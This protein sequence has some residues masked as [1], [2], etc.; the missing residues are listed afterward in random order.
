MRL[1]ILD[2][3]QRAAGD[4]GRKRV[5]EKLRPRALDERIDQRGAAGDEAAGGAAERF[6]QSSGNDVDL[7]VKP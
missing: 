2:R 3:R 1:E 6:A 4:G 5:G 7:P